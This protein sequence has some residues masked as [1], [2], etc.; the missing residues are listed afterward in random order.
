MPRQE[1]EMRLYPHNVNS[2]GEI[3]YH[4]LCEIYEKSRATLTRSAFFNNAVIKV[5]SHE[6]HLDE[7]FI[8]THRGEKYEDYIVDGRFLYTEDELVLDSDEEVH[9]QMIHP[10]IGRIERVLEVPPSVRD[11][12]V[13]S[14]QLALW[15]AGDTDALRVQW[16]GENAD[17]YQLAVA[18]RIRDGQAERTVFETNLE[19]TL[20]VKTQ[21]VLPAG[22][23]FTAHQ[24]EIEIIAS[25]N[26][27]FDFERIRFNWAV[28]SPF[29]CRLLLPEH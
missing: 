25:N 17:L 11:V 10:A 5:D 21:L 28:E 2:E 6:L 9:V 7:G 19:E 29:A 1:M 8:E 20:I 22:F 12:R 16:R 27:T 24:L 26:D 15:L 4:V 23:D 13:D 3:V 18:A 14:H